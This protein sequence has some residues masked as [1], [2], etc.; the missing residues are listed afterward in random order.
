M[1]QLLKD[2]LEY[3]SQIAD[4]IENRD[5]PKAVKYVDD[6]RFLCVCCEQVNLT[7]VSYGW[8]LAKL[9]GRK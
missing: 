6:L 5:K 3:F 9:A 7:P 8:I 2:Y 1:C 4:I